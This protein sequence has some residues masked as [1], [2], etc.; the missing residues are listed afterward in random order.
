MG[1][2][3]GSSL[4]GESDQPSTLPASDVTT[5]PIGDSP[6]SEQASASIR[7]ATPRKRDLT[8]QERV[9]LKQLRATNWIV[10]CQVTPP[11]YEGPKRAI[12]YLAR[13]VAGVAIS[14]QR[15]VSDS[16]GMVT[17]TYKDYRAKNDNDKSNKYKTLVLP[18]WEFIL[19]F[20]L[21]I[22]P[23][24]MARVRHSGLFTPSEREGRL[25]KCRE[26]LQ[27]AK[28]E[29]VGS[30]SVVAAPIYGDQEEDEE[31]VEVPKATNCPVSLLQEGYGN[32]LVD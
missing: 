5:D 16:G 12:S 6:E 30:N 1:P 21:H 3:T 25:A 9:F 13:Y 28:Q 18:V 31:P 10:D 24:G 29:Q 26:L 32:W 19:R 8:P 14:D 20:M 17:I 4:R 15:L 11:G 23:R 27:M 2:E 7:K 22:L